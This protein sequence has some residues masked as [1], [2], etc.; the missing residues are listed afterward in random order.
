ME[1]A[2]ILA[3]LL[4]TKIVANNS[5]GRK[6]IKA[7]ALPFDPP[8]SISCLALSTPIESRAAS[9]AE[10][11]AAK[12]KQRIRAKISYDETK[13]SSGG[14]MEVSLLKL[15]TVASGFYICFKLNDFKPFYFISKGL[16]SPLMT[17][18]Q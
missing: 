8:S 14:S 10:K 7:I 5:E 11:N 9:A 6:I 3:I 12:I 16:K 15:N 17:D 4:P 18:F 13:N 2:K 1:P